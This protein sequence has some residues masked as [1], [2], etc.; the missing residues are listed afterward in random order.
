MYASIQGFFALVTAHI[1]GYVVPFIA[2]R[3]QKIK[4][5]CQWVNWFTDPAATWVN[6]WITLM[7][8][9]G[10]LLFVSGMGIL[11]VLSR[12]RS[13][14]K[15]TDW[16]FGIMLWTGVLILAVTLIL[17]RVDFIPCNPFR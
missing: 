13:S 1:V 14:N 16:V 15:I 11:I 8:V 9:V 4:W 12:T 10:S 6:K 17:P 3:P 5:D 7:V 2:P